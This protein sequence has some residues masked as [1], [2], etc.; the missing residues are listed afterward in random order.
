VVLASECLPEDK[1]QM[2]IIDDDECPIDC[3]K[4]EEEG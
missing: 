1:K 4:I 3:C 2:M